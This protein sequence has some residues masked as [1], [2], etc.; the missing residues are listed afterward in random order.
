MQA[1]G[2]SEFLNQYVTER[3][4]QLVPGIFSGAPDLPDFTVDQRFEALKT[5]SYPVN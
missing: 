4:P 5:P 1:T 2:P 3:L